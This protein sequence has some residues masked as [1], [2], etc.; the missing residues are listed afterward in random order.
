[1]ADGAMI[2][3][4]P[5]D[6]SVPEGDDAVFRCVASAEPSIHTVTWS[7]QDT[8]IRPSS[9]FIITSVGADASVLTI[10]NVSTSDAGEY[11]CF[12]ANEHANASVE[13]LLD[14]LS[15]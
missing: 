7:F 6:Q 8:P 10:L 9:K 5:E 4:G 14:V 2:L 11:A 12:V 15:E 13:A 1:M 3:E